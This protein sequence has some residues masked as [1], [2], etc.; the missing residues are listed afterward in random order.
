MNW[1]KGDKQHRGGVV[2]RL[3]RLLRRCYAFNLISSS[4]T[5]KEEQ[6]CEPNEIALNRLF[7]S[8][9]AT[10]TT[11]PPGPSETAPVSGTARRVVPSQSANINSKLYLA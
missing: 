3:R 11:I 2:A 5:M 8:S 1:N 10:I 4:I 6:D 7:A 9:A